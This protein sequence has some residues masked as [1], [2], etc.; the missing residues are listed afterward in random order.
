MFLK[1]LVFVRQWVVGSGLGKP[2]TVQV[3]HL[4]IGL[5]AIDFLCNLMCL[6]RVILG[7]S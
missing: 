4:M 2:I 5:T 3:V 7:N 6:R 1:Y